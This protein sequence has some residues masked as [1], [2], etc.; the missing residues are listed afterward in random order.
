MVKADK[1]NFLVL[2][3]ARGGSKGVPK[4]NTKS[5]A[6][7]DSLV[8]RAI[9]VATSVFNKEQIVVSTDDL[10]ALQQAKSKGVIALERSPEL[11]S[12][13]SGMLEV[14]LDAI[15]RHG[16]TATHL[17]LLQP[18]SP[19]R[20]SK[21]VEQAI[22]LLQNDDQAIVAVN[23]PK[24]HPFYT[25]FEKEG[26]YIHKFKMNGVVRRQDL[27]PVYDVNGLIYIFHVESL[28]KK[29]WVEFDRIKPLVVSDL[30]AMDIDT[31]Q[32]WSLAELIEKNKTSIL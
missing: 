30:I 17:V 32:D 2:I 26:E 22:S 5:F 4:K 20:T 9:E 15:E 19:F 14:M 23:E 28:L 3:P 12:D 6:G 11:A 18:T 16:Q 29:S 31:Q 24:G 7:G 1:N 8:E 13:T 25:L 10:T 21:H 27:S